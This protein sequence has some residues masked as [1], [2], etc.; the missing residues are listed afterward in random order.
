[1]NTSPSNNRAYDIVYTDSAPNNNGIIDSQAPPP[2]V[3]V[4]PTSTQPVSQMISRALQ[5]SVSNSQ[6]FVEAV[7]QN[8]GIEAAANSARIL[9]NV[10]ERSGR[11]SFAELASVV[12]QGVQIAAQT[13]AESELAARQEERRIEEALQ[14]E[15]QSEA[16][17][18]LE[19]AQQQLRLEAPDLLRAETGDVGYR[20][21]VED[22]ITRYRG[23]ADEETVVR[24]MGELYG[25]LMDYNR[26]LVTATQGTLQAQMDANRAITQRQFMVRYSGRFAQLSVAAT[27]EEQ[28][29]L[30][31]EIT[32]SITADTASMTPFDRANV[33]ESLL[34]PLSESYDLSTGRFVQAN[35]QLRAIQSYS[36]EIADA[37]AVYE[38]DRNLSNF[39]FN[40]QRIAS[41]YPDLPDNVRYNSPDQDVRHALETQQLQQ[42]VQ[43]A[44]KQALLSAGE[45][46]QVGQD[47]VTDLAYTLFS[48][49]ASA[50]LY[51]SV[52]GSNPE[53]L[54]AQAVAEL[55]REQQTVNESANQRIAQLQ[56]DKQALNTQN[57]SQTLS[58]A[59]SQ[60][61]AQREQYA[62]TLRNLLNVPGVSADVRA[63]AEARLNAPE[64]AIPQSDIDTL[65]AAIN[66]SREQSIAIIDNQVALEVR[67]INDAAAMLRP[68]GLDTPEGVTEQ[69][70]NSRAN[71]ESLNTRIRQTQRDVNAQ[72]GRPNIPGSSR[73]NANFNMPRLATATS[74]NITAALPFAEGT[75]SPLTGGDGLF[76]Q[77]RQYYNN[78]AGGYHQGL[79]V[80]V[81]IGTP[82]INYNGGI[83]TYVGTLDGYGNYVEVTH[84]DG[85]VSRF[86]HLDS[87][88]VTEGQRVEAGATLA[89][90][91]NTGRSDGP[92]LHWEVRVPSEQAGGGAA[93]NPLEYTSALSANT[94]ANPRR[95]RNGQETSSGSGMQLGNGQ[96]LNAYSDSTRYNTDNPLRQR[97]ASTRA[98]DYT[99]SADGSA[100]YG[101]EVLARDRP[102]R[103]ALHRTAQSMGI[104]TQWL[105][106]VM[107]YETG[108]TF[109]SSTT[110]S[111]GA[112]GL[113]QFIPETLAA[114]GHTVSSVANMSNVEQLSLVK[115][116][117]NDVRSEAG[118]DAWQNPYQL[119]MAVWGGGNNLRRF[120]E[121]PESVRNIGDGDLTWLEYTQRL[122]RDAGRRYA[123]IYD[124]PVQ[125][126]SFVQGCPTCVAMLGDVGT[127]AS[128]ITAY[129]DVG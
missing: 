113:I 118:L 34:T 50:P 81:A 128:H 48:N 7:T 58:W 25:P 82:V 42:S 86:A 129:G 99:R 71:L 15:A 121:D 6:R 11:S 30:T 21:R 61:A 88:N 103:L 55:L 16:N 109:S 36:A 104:P 53:Y 10:R 23:T 120:V 33:L 66:Q 20:R 101:Y 12:Q 3:N 22:L 92:H 93:I 107:G 67:R 127:F 91:G 80:A 4:Q 19:Q 56:L 126:S 105:A 69:L 31:D 2:T 84:D 38:Q 75:D 57:I 41:Q 68:Y 47:T 116:Y 18:D 125:H 123:P 64:Q 37:L 97:F 98:A 5:G 32:S 112:T 115:Q 111:I 27:P 106:D 79:D 46:I 78:G 51:D 114:Y 52:L 35:S 89:R 39:R 108:A 14:A 60:N 87:Y 95:P 77:Y 43:D 9:R 124:A 40:E 83:V 100:N 45:A 17:I 62:N 119:L 74:G 49:P 90:S 59:N 44:R 73:A 102:F 28:Q 13:R 65:N 85:Y 110:N 24:V 26:E 1:M 117:L 94:N 54:Q 76:N 29:R 70:R 96:R 63:L 72:Q 8:A 122:G